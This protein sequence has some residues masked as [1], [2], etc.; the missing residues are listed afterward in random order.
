MS[1]V[2]HTIHVDHRDQ[3]GTKKSK[4]L[5]AQGIVPATLYGSGIKEP[6]SLQVS[7]REFSILLDNVEESSLVDIVYKKK[8]YK[9]LLRNI[10][11]NPLK[12]EFFSVDF[13]APNLK[14]TTEVEVALHFVGVSESESQGNM[15]IK[16]HDSVLIEALPTELPEF[17]EVDI[18]ELKT[19]DDLIRAGDVQL[20]T[21]VT[22][23]LDP[24]EVIAYTEAPRTEEEPDDLSSAEMDAIEAAQTAAPNEEKSSEE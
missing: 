3:I 11:R 17:I 13:Y 23:Q 21:G 24:D 15:L 5:R 18:S 4:L 8:T 14:E 22:L 6:I 12:N 16:S 7:A 19:V 1:T 9:T 20:P 2:S 10:E